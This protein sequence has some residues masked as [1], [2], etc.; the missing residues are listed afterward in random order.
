MV[1][2]PQLGNNILALSAA[3]E[4]PVKITLKATFP[5]SHEYDMHHT[6]TKVL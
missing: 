2:D 3:F 6:Q 4:G 5:R 1:L